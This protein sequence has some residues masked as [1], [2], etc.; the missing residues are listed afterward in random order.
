MI[1]GSLHNHTNLSDGE[2]SLEVMADAAHRMGWSWLG[3]RTTPR[4]WSSPTVLL[5]TICGPRRDRPSRQRGW[6]EQGKDFR[7]F[8]G[9]ESD[10][11]EAGNSTIL[12][13]C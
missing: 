10:V 3:W 1:R 11:L 5:L 13:R 12:M 4:R 6:A 9:V 8:H 2:A 7:L